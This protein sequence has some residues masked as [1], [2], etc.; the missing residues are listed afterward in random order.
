MDRKQS[1]MR[2]I[3]NYSKKLENKNKPKSPSKKRESPEK[4]VVAGLCKWLKDY[5]FSYDII[6]AST[7]DRNNSEG[8]TTKVSA[9]FSDIVAVD[10]W[11]FGVF[12]EAKAP[13]RRKSGLKE[14]QYNFLRMKIM[15][16]A[17]ACCTDSAE[18]LHDL[19]HKWI[20]LKLKVRELQVLKPISMFQAGQKS[21]VQLLL[22]DLP[23]PKAVRDD[24]PNAELGF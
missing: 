1:V 4:K 19:Y 12:I 20:V 13:G 18:H 7:Y 5:G 3:E 10:R 21:P 8:H 16:N 22:A 17:F 24:K 15:N 2:A 11:G 9:G 6:E 23:V 14:H